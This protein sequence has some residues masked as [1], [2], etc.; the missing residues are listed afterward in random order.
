[1][2]QKPLNQQKA[3]SKDAIAN[4]LAADRGRRATFQATNHLGS[5][6]PT[7]FEINL[8]VAPSS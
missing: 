1:M 5:E 2:R 3:F 8:F 6:S 7:D 4:R